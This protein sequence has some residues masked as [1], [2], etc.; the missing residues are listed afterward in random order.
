MLDC[1]HALDT[2]LSRLQAH[3]LRAYAEF[4]HL[5]TSRTSAVA[6]VALELTQHETFIGT[7]FALAEDLTT[8]MPVT[9]AALEAGAIDEYK[10]SPVRSPISLTRTRVRRMR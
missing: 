6:E 7:R 8:R 1:I 3:R 9:L 5:S 2:D 10:A 4:E